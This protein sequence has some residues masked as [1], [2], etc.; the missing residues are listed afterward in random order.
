MFIMVEV[1]SK[2]RW[3][4]YKYMLGPDL[5][6][7][8][9]DT[10]LYNFDDK[11]YGRAFLFLDNANAPFP[12]PPDENDYDDDGLLAASTDTGVQILRI[13]CDTSGGPQDDD[14]ADTAVVDRQGLIIDS[15]HRCTAGGTSRRNLPKT[16]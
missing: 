6:L 11:K 13:K 15:I 8:E 1:S 12:K 3:S 16:S 7:Y 9:D 2:R 14:D 5:S 10:G 4:R